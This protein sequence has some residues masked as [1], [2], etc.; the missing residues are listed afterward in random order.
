MQSLKFSELLEAELMQNIL[1]DGLMGEEELRDIFVTAGASSP[2]RGKGTADLV[3]PESK[4]ETFISSFREYFDGLMDELDDE[5]TDVSD[6]LDEMT[7]EDKD[8]SIDDMMMMASHR[9]E[10]SVLE[11]EIVESSS[12]SKLGDLED[13]AALVEEVFRSLAGT[14]SRVSTKDMLNWDLCDDLIVQGLLTEESLAE[15]MEDCGADKKGVDLEGFDKLVD[16]LVSLYD[17]LPDND[18]EIEIDDISSLNLDEELLG[19]DEGDELADDEEVIDIDIEE[20]FAKVSNGKE[21]MTLEV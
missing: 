6:E 2:K 16:K 9:P 20:E 1:E 4:F 8:E 12:N 18:D 13:D 5:E 14:K 17:N 21:Y 19:A 15:I 7:P 10:I 3:L 11:P